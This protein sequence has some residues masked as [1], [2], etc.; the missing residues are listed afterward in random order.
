MFTKKM[1][2]IFSSAIDRKVKV[3][4]DRKIKLAR[5]DSDDEFSDTSDEYASVQLSDDE[6]ANPTQQRN[7]I[8]NETQQTDQ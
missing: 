5:M 8:L 4:K 2:S 7:L 3:A 6:N 1:V